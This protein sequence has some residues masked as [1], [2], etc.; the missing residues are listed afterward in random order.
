MA[1]RWAAFAAGSVPFLL[2]LGGLN[3]RLYGHALASGYGNLRDLFSIAHVPANVGHYGSAIVETELGLPLLG[4]AAVVLI[5]RSRRAPLW[6]TLACCAATSGVY[7]LYR[8]FDEWWYLRFLLPAL[9]PLTVMGASVLV[10]ST[11]CVL[12]GP[13]A[14]RAALA[15]IV[16]LAA[17]WGLRT[18]VNRQA[19]NLAGFE[20]RFLASAE[21]ARSR[22]PGHAVFVTVWHS[23]TM[24]FHAGRPAVLWDALAPDALDPA[25]AW[26]AGRGLEPYLVIEDWEEPTFRARFAGHSAFAGLDWPPRFEIERRVRIY[27]PSDRANYLSGGAVPSERVITR[28]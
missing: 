8:P 11:D 24:R 26:L 5:P 6:L 21:V 27:R 14:R 25:V 12:A 22:L 4:I 10:L 15:T 9:A 23:G 7:L 2:V 3:Q 19:F 18:A 17:S 13:R 1:R 20:R 28:F 16:V